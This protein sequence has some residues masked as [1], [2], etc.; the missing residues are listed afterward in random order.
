VGARVVWVVGRFRGARGGVRG[1]APP[2]S[3]LVGELRREERRLAAAP[4]NILGS[5]GLVGLFSCG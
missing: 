2:G 3:S 5:R 1:G 4:L